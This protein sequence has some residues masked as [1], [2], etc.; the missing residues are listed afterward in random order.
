MAGSDL[1]LCLQK[2]LRSMEYGGYRFALV[3]AAIGVRPR[4]RIIWFKAFP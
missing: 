4:M 3:A 2:V 1:Q